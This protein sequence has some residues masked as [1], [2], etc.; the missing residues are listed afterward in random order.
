MKNSKVLDEDGK[1]VTQGGSYTD[2]WEEYNCYAFAINR[3][4]LPHFYDSGVWL[5]YQPGNMSGVVDAVLPDTIDELVGII[6]ADFLNMGYSDFSASRTLPTINST[7]ELI[8]V[9]KGLTDYHFMRYDLQ[10]DAWYHKPSITAVLRYNGTPSNAVDWNN[11]ASYKGRVYK[12]TKIYDSDIVYITYTK[13]QIN[14]AD[15]MD[16]TAIIHYGKMY[17][18]N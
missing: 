8:C 16:S 17:S 4:E 5:S 18:M 10:T 6:Q 9:R 3:V 2:L 1:W 15:S 11:E 12:P 13:N 7:Q 14:V